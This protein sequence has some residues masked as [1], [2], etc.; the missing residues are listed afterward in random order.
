[1][2][3]LFIFLTN[4]LV[5]PALYSARETA[6]SLAEWI[7]APYR[8]LEIEIFSPIWRN[9]VDPSMAA[10]EW[11]MVTVSSGLF[12]SRTISEVMSLVMLAMGRR[13][14]MFFS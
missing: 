13:W 14:C 10:A 6:A 5:E 7:M 2:A 1:M 9:I 8:R 12:S 3:L 11:L 4:S